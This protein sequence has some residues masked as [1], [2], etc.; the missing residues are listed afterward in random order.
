MFVL[1]MSFALDLNIL[2]S[3]QLDG[4]TLW[5]TDP[6]PVLIPPLRKMYPLANIGTLLQRINPILLSPFYP[7]F[8]SSQHCAIFAKGLLR[9]MVGEM[10]SKNILFLEI[11]PF[12]QDHLNI[13]TRKSY[14]IIMLTTCD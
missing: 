5:V 12:K 11:H 2:N 6:S 7:P 8:L 3:I 13:A 9:A 10:E 14:L 4:A 1:G